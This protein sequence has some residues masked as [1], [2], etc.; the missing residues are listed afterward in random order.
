MAKG[1]GLFCFIVAFWAAGFA[2]PSPGAVFDV[3]DYGAKGD[4]LTKDT[5]AIQRAIDA[6]HA[7]GGG[8]VDVPPGVY[9]TG[10][11]F[12]KSNVDFHL[13]AGAVVRGSPDR[14][15]YN[16]ADVCPQNAASPKTGDNTSGAHLI[17]CIAQTNVTLSGTGCID[18]HAPAFLCDENKRPYPSKKEI[19]WRPAQ[20]VWFV[21]CRHVRIHD[22]EMARA[23]YWSCFLLNCDHVSVR[24][25][26]I[27]T[28]RKPHT[29]N[30]DGLDIDRCRYVTVSDC[31]IDTADD[32]I[33]LRASYDTRLQDPHDCAYVT[34]AN[35][36]LSTSCNAIRLGVG[37]GKID[38][39]VFS[40]L[41]IHNTR[42]AFNYV[43][44]YSKTSRGTDIAHVRVSNVIVDAA[45]FLRMHHMYAQETLFDNLYF[46]DISGH[47]T[48]PSRI[49]ACSKTPFGKIFFRNVDL[50][51]GFEA[52]NAPHVTCTGGSFA[53]LALSEEDRQK[54]TAAID[55]QK[56]LLY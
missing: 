45:N 26:Y 27:H 10:S 29:F 39:A 35:C 28:L 30:G 24:G 16:S 47:V 54:K 21:D 8:K 49:Y 9:L 38:H 55:A 17:L 6:A 43:S 19:V 12:L 15:D 5:P 51:C 20:M 32:C 7:A 44:S 23:P 53:P 31:R 50:P 22:V 52:I 13:Q 33:T 2:R 3:K 46:S 1:K 48:A 41:V 14:Q 37:G 42:T 34:V 25:C 18:G 56:G 40:N 11:L 36:V 4:G